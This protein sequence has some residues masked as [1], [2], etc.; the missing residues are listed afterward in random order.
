MADTL[1]TGGTW[2]VEILDESLLTVK[3]TGNAYTFSAKQDDRFGT[4]TVRFNYTYTDHRDTAR[5]GSIGEG[6]RLG[7]HIINIVAVPGGII[8]E[9]DQHQAGL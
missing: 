5:D 3:N 9:Y 1:H 7:R 8:D 4:T 2:E 6:S